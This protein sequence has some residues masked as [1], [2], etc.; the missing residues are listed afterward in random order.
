[1]PIIFEALSD[2]KRLKEVDFSS[3]NVFDIGLKGICPFIGQN[4]KSRIRSIK[5]NQNEISDVG[6]KKFLKAIED[7]QNCLQEMAF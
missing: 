6:F 5:F 2:L 3:N 1:M 4:Y 7:N